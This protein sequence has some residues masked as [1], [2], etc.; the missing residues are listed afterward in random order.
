MSVENNPQTGQIIYLAGPSSSGKSTYSK[1]LLKSGYI[2]LEHDVVFQDVRVQLLG[3][4]PGEDLEYVKSHLKNQSSANIIHVICNGK[5]PEIEPKDKKKFDAAIQKLKIYVETVI[6][7]KGSDIC[8]DS[9]VMM[10]DKAKEM[11]L[12]G[13]NVI[14][15]AV[16]MLN[17]EIRCDDIVLH[18]EKNRDLWKYKGVVIEQR[19][20]YVSIERLMLNVIRRNQNPEEFRNPINALHQFS[21]R[22]QVL[23]VGG[24]K[25]GS[26]EVS[27]LKKWIERAV[28]MNFFVI[29]PEHCFVYK[30]EKDA[31]FD[32][33]H[34]DKSL[35]GRVT[36]FVK[37]MQILSSSKEA[38]EKEKGQRKLAEMAKMTNTIAEK[39]KEIL[40]AMRIPTGAL[41]VDLTFHSST[42]AQPIIVS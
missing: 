39:T 38:G 17:D 14:I 30:E 11:A 16:P 22:F 32:D 15:D 10:L 2:H 1:D 34:F 3:K 7:P 13:K 19:L 24:K 4:A 31:K 26:L 40:E 9:F 25:V 28:K 12:I 42:G 29:N 36:D 5:R 8:Y 27:N 41:T 21:D 35:D 33:V 23:G 37:E 6:D 20:K 18:K